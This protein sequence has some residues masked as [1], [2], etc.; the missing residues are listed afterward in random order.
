[1]GDAWE[2]G[3]S[4]NAATSESACLPNEG[5]NRK[6][7]MPR[8]AG[9]GLWITLTLHNE[10]RGDEMRG[11]DFSL[12]EKSPDT[13]SPAE[14]SGTNRNVERLFSFHGTRILLRNLSEARISGAG[15]LGR[16]SIK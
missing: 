7:K 4:P 5:R 10:E 11:G 15:R 3:N 2:D 14:T 9:D 8:K 1:L 12:R 16:L 13:R 6:T